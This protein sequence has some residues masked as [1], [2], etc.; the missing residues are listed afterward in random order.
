M[1][2]PYNSQRAYSNS[3]LANLLFAFELQRQATARGL[4]LASVAAHPGRRRD[5][6]V[7]RSAG[8]GREPRSCAW[9][10]P[11]FL[12]VV[13]PVGRR[14]ARTGDLFA[15]TAAEPG[16]YTGPQRFGET[17]GPI[18]P[19]RLSPLAQDDAAGPAAVAR[20]RGADRLSL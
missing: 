16:S 18:G 1:G 6:A 3:K 2:E 12:K 7:L 9:S 11:L 10:A 14:P 13:D 20:Q 4:A 17:R 19:A 8:H 15:A 5:R